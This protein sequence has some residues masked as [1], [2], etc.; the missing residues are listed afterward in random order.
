M[1]AVSS[2]TLLQ[3]CKLTHPHSL[4][5]QERGDVVRYW[6]GTGDIALQASPGLPEVYV[7]YSAERAVY[8]KHV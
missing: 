4:A 5:I 6:A 7:P 2:K 8:F 3:H 1:T